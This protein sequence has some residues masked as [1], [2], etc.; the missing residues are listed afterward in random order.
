MARE[1]VEEEYKVESGII[2][3]PGKFGGRMVY[4]PHF[5]GV[6]LDGGEEFFVT[7]N[8]ANGEIVTDDYP[9]EYEGILVTAIKINEEDIFE[10]PELAEN[11]YDAG[12][13]ICLI[14]TEQGF[15]Y[16]TDIGYCAKLAKE[17]YD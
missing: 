5:W 3:S 16:E 17:Y 10:F 6:T 7:V 1:K 9:E 2:E 4:L 14:E 12:S 11:G 13:H 8:P 15:V